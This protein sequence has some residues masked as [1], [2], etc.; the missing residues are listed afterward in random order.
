MFARKK[1]TYKIL[2]TN[3]VKYNGAQFNT[4]NIFLKKKKLFFLT[5]YFTFLR[6]NNNKNDYLTLTPDRDLTIPSHVHSQSLVTL[7]VNIRTDDLLVD[8]YKSILD[9]NI[10]LRYGHD[11]HD[12][13]VH[14]TMVATP[15]N[16]NNNTK[17]FFSLLR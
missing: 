13:A 10:Q 8:L 7:H 11:G 14:C 16:T 1:T 3:D 5:K 2:T 17:F 9:Q 6:R 4:K 12:D 15:D